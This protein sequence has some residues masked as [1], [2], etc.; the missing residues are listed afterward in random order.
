MFLA[1]VKAHKQA[2]P[3]CASAGTSS[4]VNSNTSSGS[5][6]TSARPGSPTSSND[7]SSTGNNKIVFVHDYV[8]CDYAAKLIVDFNARNGSTVSFNPGRSK[9]VFP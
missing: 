2:L 6:S 8:K 5:I 7:K 4:F 3:K 1:L 9:L